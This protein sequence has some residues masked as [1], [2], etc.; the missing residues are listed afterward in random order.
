M[1]VMNKYCVEYTARLFVDA[2]SKNEAREKAND[3]TNAL[4]LGDLELN[5]PDVER[6]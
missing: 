4:E 5:F 3:I 6:V 2:E 1:E